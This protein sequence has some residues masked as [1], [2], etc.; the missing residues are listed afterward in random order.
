[1]ACNGGK[2]SKT[3]KGKYNKKQNLIKPS[4]YTVDSKGNI[5][6]VYK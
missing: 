5:K 1:M 2:G 3:K 6:P 4:S